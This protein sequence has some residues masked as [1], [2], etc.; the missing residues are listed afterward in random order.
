MKTVNKRGA[1]SK[2]F[3]F[4]ELVNFI[5]YEPKSAIIHAGTNDLTNRIN[6]LNNVKK[7]VKELKT[8][9]PKLKTAF[10]GLIPRKDQKYR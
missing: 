6:M 9:L 4:K 1:I 2:R 3:L 7:I 10:S 8:K 5:K